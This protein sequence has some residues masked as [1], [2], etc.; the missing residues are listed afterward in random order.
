YIQNKKNYLS[1]RNKVFDCII[2][3]FKNDYFTVINDS[4][5][6]HIFFDSLR[7]PYLT[8]KMKYEIAQSALSSF[9]GISEQEIREVIDDISQRNW[10]IDWDTSTSDSIERLL[11][12]KELKSPYGH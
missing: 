5:L 6:A 12:K 2:A 8:D 4:E 11:M 9:S 7:C 10:F 1:T 3:K